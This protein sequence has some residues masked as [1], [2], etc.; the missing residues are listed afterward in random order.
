[1]N[2]SAETTSGQSPAGRQADVADRHVSAWTFR[3]KVVRVLW[4]IVQATLFRWSFRTMNGWR[5][6][7]LRLFGAKV[8][9]D[10][11]IRPSVHIE[12]PWNIR[13]GDHVAL[14]DRVILYSLGPITIGD[15]TSISQYA[16]LCAGTH[17]H[18]RPDLP[19][20]RPPITLGADVWIA[21]DVFVGPGVTVG[22][23]A[24]VGARSNVF[25][26]L[27]AWKICVGSPARAMKDREYP[28]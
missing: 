12:I 14:G 7:L 24:V 2:G 16:H 21:T 25:S 18:T 27:P 3:E 4:S 20:L 5:S 22:E 19:L 17:D 9:R 1:M 8:G 28:K 13:L 6:F 15:R 23:G 10:C 26:D 11:V